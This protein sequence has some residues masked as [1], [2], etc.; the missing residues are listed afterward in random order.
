MNIFM[1]M[2][3]YAFIYIIIHIRFRLRGSSRVVAA[4]ALVT[5]LRGAF[6][7]HGREVPRLRGILV[8]LYRQ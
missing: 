1:H 8:V 6:H 4:A 5:N 3:T 7:A 2:I